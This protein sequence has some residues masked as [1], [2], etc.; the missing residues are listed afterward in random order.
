M[1]PHHHEATGCL[2]ENC[3]GWAHHK[4]GGMACETLGYDVAFYAAMK[5]EGKLTTENNENWETII[6]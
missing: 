5:L 4:V 3:H 2:F 1:Q 6:H